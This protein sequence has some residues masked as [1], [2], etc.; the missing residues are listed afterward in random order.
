MLHH[1]WSIDAKSLHASLTQPKAT[2]SSVSTKRIRFRKSV[3]VIEVPVVGRQNPVR[4]RPR[5]YPV[6][7]KTAKDVPVSPKVE[8]QEAQVRARQLQETVKLHDTDAE[9]S[10]GFCCWTGDIRYHM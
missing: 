2:S 7:Y 3:H 5:E 8:Q 4:H 6:V 1:A 10:C 9:P